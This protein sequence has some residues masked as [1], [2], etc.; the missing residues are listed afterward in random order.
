MNQ[1]LRCSLSNGTGEA[2]LL[3]GSEEEP[4]KNSRG[5]FVDRTQRLVFI[6]DGCS[7]K[8]QEGHTK[9]NERIQQVF[10]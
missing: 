10:D 3:V 2:V 5:I 7:A 4:L 8:V 1:T 6:D 9:P